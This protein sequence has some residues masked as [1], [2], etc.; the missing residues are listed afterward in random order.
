MHSSRNKLCVSAMPARAWKCSEIL[1]VE[2]GVMVCGGGL[3]V[4]GLPGFSLG[5]P[6]L[7]GLLVLPGQGATSCP[8]QL[9][10]RPCADA[11]LPSDR[12]CLFQP[13]PR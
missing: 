11:A 9:C 3:C 12:R 8:R 1:E 10:T 2:R 4:C 6:P 5:G 7:T 13:D